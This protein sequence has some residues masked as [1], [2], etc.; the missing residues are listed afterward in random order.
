MPRRKVPQLRHRSTT[1]PRRPGPWKT[2]RP[3]ACTVQALP[4]VVVASP[5]STVVPAPSRTT[6]STSL[7]ALSRTTSNTAT[8]TSLPTPRWR[9]SVTLLRTRQHQLQNLLLAT[10]VPIIGFAAC[11]PS[12]ETDHLINQGK[13]VQPKPSLEP[14]PS[15][16]QITAHQ[17]RLDRFKDDQARRQQ[18]PSAPLSSHPQHARPSNTKRH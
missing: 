3:W 4:T 18:P 15:S 2:L 1:T 10:P 14:T 8:T 9:R 16:A 7:P 11:R 13:R 5:A 12:L 6:S 17:R